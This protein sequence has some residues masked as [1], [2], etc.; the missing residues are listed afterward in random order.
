VGRGG[1]ISQNDF[2]RPILNL[3]Q[4]GEDALLTK[5]QEIQLAKQIEVGVFAEKIL[6]G[7]VE[8]A[9]VQPPPAAEELHLLVADGQEAFEHMVLANLG[10]VKKFANEYKR[11][12]STLF[13]DAFGEGNLGLIHAVKKFDYQKGY[14]FS[15]YAAF[16]IKKNILW[17]RAVDDF[18]CGSLSRVLALKLSAQDN[19]ARKLYV[20]LGR[21]PTVEELTDAVNA[22][23]K[24]S[25]NR[26]KREDVV[27]RKVLLQSI[28][29]LDDPR[30]GDKDL[31]CDAEI[32]DPGDEVLQNI[33]DQL[34][35]T[36]VTSELTAKERA[37][38]SLSYGF[39]TIPGQSKV[40]A[41]HISKQLDLS[42]EA[43]WQLQDQALEK[44]RNSQAARQLISF[45][46]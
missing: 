6:A 13:D 33:R 46:V 35:R 42:D 3:E 32:T 44:L 22:N 27:Y 14:K 28:I 11:R 17:L 40:T 34:I 38:I 16:W 9:H 41:K 26:V 4:A 5:E 18:G 37:V 30:Y 31:I 10:L 23:V 29:H 39:D 12:G 7:E 45:L 36:M 1:T 43:V 2:R 20:E 15:T 25:E 21:E 24:N 8:T 19:K